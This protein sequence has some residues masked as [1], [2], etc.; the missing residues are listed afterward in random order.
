MLLTECWTLSRPAFG[1]FLLRTSLR[2]QPLSR[3][4][5]RLFRFL[6]ASSAPSYRAHQ[7]SRYISVL[8]CSITSWS[9]S[10]PEQVWSFKLDSAPFNSVSALESCLPARGEEP[11][12]LAFSLIQFFRMLVRR[13]LEPAA[14][15]LHKEGCSGRRK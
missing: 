2:A 15:R 10:S 3:R 7:L 13:A 9:A 11:R 4:R 14:R 12:V 5:E 6:L 8:G 1:F